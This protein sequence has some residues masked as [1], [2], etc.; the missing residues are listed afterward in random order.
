MNNDLFSLIPDWEETPRSLRKKKQNTLS[1]LHK[2][3]K[4]APK[5]Q[6]VLQFTTSVEDAEQLTCKL[7]WLNDTNWSSSISGTGNWVMENGIAER[8]SYFQCQFVSQ[9]NKHNS[10]NELIQSYYWPLRATFAQLLR[11]LI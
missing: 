7:Y 6:K 4:Y 2:A 9:F 1:P 10:P 3:Y 5:R 11:E 8:E